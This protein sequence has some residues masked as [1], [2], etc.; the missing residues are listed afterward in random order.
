MVHANHENGTRIKAE[1]KRSLM[2]S[3]IP[4]AIPLQCRCNRGLS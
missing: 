1:V 3:F 4:P 2:E